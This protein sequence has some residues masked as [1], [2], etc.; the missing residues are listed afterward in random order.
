[1]ALLLPLLPPAP[2]AD[3][4]GH[5]VQPPHLEGPW[6]LPA[7]HHGAVLGL[8]HVCTMSYIKPAGCWAPAPVAAPSSLLDPGIA[9]CLVRGS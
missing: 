8:A 7:Q 9:L 5:S 1:M 2:G 3:S 4:S 6:S